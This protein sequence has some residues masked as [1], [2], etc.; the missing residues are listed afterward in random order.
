[1]LARGNRYG[2]I[3]RALIAFLHGTL[4]ATLSVTAQS[5]GQLLY[6]T[7]NVACHTKQMHWRDGRAARKWTSLKFQVRR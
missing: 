2:F 1:L 7:H 4:A 6:T 5:R 3:V